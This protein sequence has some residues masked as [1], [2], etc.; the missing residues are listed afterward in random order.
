MFEQL[1]ENPNHVKF[2]LR[3]TAKSNQFERISKN[4]LNQD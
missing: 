4:K 3:F 1:E 2:D